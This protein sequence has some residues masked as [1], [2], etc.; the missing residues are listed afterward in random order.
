M[1][2]VSFPTLP[3]LSPS[4]N[5]LPVDLPEIDLADG[6]DILLTAETDLSLDG[7]AKPGWLV[8]TRRYVVVLELPAT[9]AL[10]DAA[11][12]DFET[13]RAEALP[14]G[15]TCFALA[16]IEG[17]RN[18]SGVGAGM[19]QLKIAETWIDVLRFSN[20]HAD[21]FHYIASKLDRFRNDGQL[22]EVDGEQREALRCSSCGLRLQSTLE[23]CP[24]CFHKHRIFQ[25]VKDLLFPQLGMTV[26]LCALTMLGV[27]AELVPPKLQQYL[28]DNILTASSRSAQPQPQDFLGLLLIVVLGLAASRVVL[29]GVEVFKGR[30]ATTIGTRLTSHLRG[31]MVDRLQHLAIAYYDRHQ[32][33]SLISRV[34]H[35]S[36]SIHGLVHQMTGGF[37][38][39]ILQLV[40][41]WIMLLSLNWK[42]ALFTL[43]PVPLL[44][45]GTWT[46]WKYV[47][48]RHFR[49]W[50]AASRQIAVLSG[51][52]SGIRVVK[53]FAQES[54][55][56][57]KYQKYSQHLR[58]SRL[59]VEYASSMYAASMQLI[60]SLGGLIVWY[61]GGRDVIGGEMTLGELIAFLAYLAMFYTPLTNLSNFT[62]WFSNFMTGNKR[63]MEILD[64]SVGIPQKEVTTPWENIQGRIQ[65][66]HVTFGYDRHQP[67][68][69]DVSFEVAA[70]E[71]VGIVGRSG[72]GKST[73]VN[74]LGRFYDVQEGRILI[75]GIDLRD[76]SLTQLR[77][78]LGI[79]FQESFLFRGLIWDN[80]VY[81][82]PATTIEEGLA[83][84]KAAGAHDFI[85]RNRLG[86][87]TPLGEQGAGLSGGEK[88]RLSIARTLLYDPRILVLDEATSNIDAEAEREIQQA[89]DVL[90]KGRTTIA[91]AH[92]LSTLRNADR[93]LVFDRGRLIEQGSHADLL[94]QEGTYAR[95]VKIQT[96]ISKGDSIDR[97]VQQEPATIPQTIPEPSQQQDDQDAQTK[98]A[99]GL[100]WLVPQ[101]Y[102][103][104]AGDQGELKLVAR[105]S[106]RDDP[107]LKKVDEAYGLSLLSLFPSRYPEQYLSLRAWNEHGDD[108]EVAMI[109]NIHDWDPRSQALMRLTLAKRY[110]FRRIRRVYELKLAQGYLEFDVE[111]GAGRET[112]LMR[113]ISQ[114]VQDFGESGKIITDTEENQYLIEDVNELPAADRGLFQRYVYW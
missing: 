50:D 79:V 98:K 34:A 33:G 105:F 32:V 100:T 72:S 53:A 61:V 40:G 84:A 63:V 4:K 36:E 47:Y 97:L 75:D 14:P 18:L 46:F 69:H 19:L 48:P 114:N 7:T 95:L 51:M 76:L 23:S 25:Q 89:L 28:V 65:F 17:V 113:W 94:Q 37:L 39:Q 82:R 45:V 2:K 55:E 24:R 70:G 73:M 108:T 29:S 86:Y 101:E 27:A 5:S 104:V 41:V 74:L 109:G 68:L 103:F 13:R 96:Q 110:L 26:L 111:T 77:E 22:Q 81:G 6:C 99:T 3:V 56:Y 11:V 9:D 106:D 67:V 43:I 44:F 10:V 8:L 87:E 91:I 35:D 80:L 54:R 38:L 60:F 102:Q 20:R 1:T 15:A 107:T 90:V 62:S 16:D 83:A 42:L 93:I 57:E 92:R 78:H 30:L 85:C 49:L 59:R 64:T 12:S 66:E 31:R 52:L 112:F 88:Q 58:Q 21:R 71:M